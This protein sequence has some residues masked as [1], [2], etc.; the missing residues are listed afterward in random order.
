MKDRQA[1][2]IDRKL[3]LELDQSPMGDIT[4]GDEMTREVDDITDIQ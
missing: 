2:E 1:V 3:S 4:A